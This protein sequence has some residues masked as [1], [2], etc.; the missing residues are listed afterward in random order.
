MP[1]LLA[2]YAV[3][4]AGADTSSLTTPSFTPVNGE[5]IVVKLATWDT[6]NPMGAVSGGGQTYTTRV[7]AAPGGFNC[8]ARIVTAVV[9]GSP[10]SMAVTAAGTASNSRHSMVVERWSGQLAASPAVNATVNGT[11]SAPSAAITTVGTG[12]VLSWCS[13]D[14]NS[15]DP[16]GRTYL[17]SATEDGLFNG[18]GGN[19]VQYFAFAGVGAAGTY[20]IGM[21]APAPQIWVMA[22]VEIL[23]AAPSSVTP[24]PFTGTTGRPSSGTTARPF[25]GITVRP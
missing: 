1:T 5:V 13:V 19:S 22:G 12:S 7:T 14:N 20:N 21:S 8:W 6:N 25:T 4:S 16:T 24:R 11:G 10:G 3:Y 18:V 2:S 15:L 9:A 17:L 23:A